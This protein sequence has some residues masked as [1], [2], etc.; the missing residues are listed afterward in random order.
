[1]YDKSAYSGQGNRAPLKEWHTVNDEADEKLR[2]VI[3]EGWCVGFR[4]LTEEEVK[5]SWDLAV[6][7]RD[8]GNYKG[9]LGWNSLESIQYV[10]NALKKYDEITK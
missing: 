9:R 2:V 3:F 8:K 1:M 10:N 4:A 7:Q 5:H 6:Y